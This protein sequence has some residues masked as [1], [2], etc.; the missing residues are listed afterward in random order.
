MS[1]QVDITKPLSDEDRAYLESRARHDLLA[2]NDR[3]TND[4]ST[5]PAPEVVNDGHTGDVDPF[6]EDDGSDLLAGTHPGE[7][8]VNPIQA[9]ESRGTSD[10][11]DEDKDPDEV[12]PVNVEPSIQAG[13]GDAASTEDDEYSDM[14]NEELREEL[15]SR[16]LS[17][18]GSKAE[19]QARLRKDDAE[20]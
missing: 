1:R 4:R 15:E 17:K 12:Y 13:D 5:D 20:A 18:S 8:P 2:Q 3:I 6:K 11:G 7:T 9:I 10:L 16:D 14:T 19:M